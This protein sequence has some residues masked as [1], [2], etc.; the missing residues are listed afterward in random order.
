MVDRFEQKPNRTRRSRVCFVSRFSAVSD[1]VWGSGQGLGLRPYLHTTTKH[2]PV[3]KQ[4]AALPLEDIAGRSVNSP[5]FN[6]VFSF[7][8][9][10]FT[11]VFSLACLIPTSFLSFHICFFLFSFYL[12]YIICS[13]ILFCNLLGLCWNSYHVY[14]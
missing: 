1:P 13:S 3:R 11:C 6:C 7:A 5:P 10:F 12:V 9:I 2:F 14:I 4:R 8:C